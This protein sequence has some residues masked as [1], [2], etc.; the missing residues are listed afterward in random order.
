MTTIHPTQPNP[1]HPHIAVKTT[2]PLKIYSNQS[3]ND[4]QWLPMTTNDYQWLL[5]TIKDYQRLSR[6]I[7]DYQRLSKGLNANY[8]RWLCDSVMSYVTFTFLS[9]ILERM[10]LCASF[11]LSS[12]F[13]KVIS[14]KSSHFLIKIQTIQSFVKGIFWY[15]SIYL[16][17]VTLVVEEIQFWKIPWKYAS[18]AILV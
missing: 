5:K 1:I 8:G 14:G 9:F 3:T 13:T 17:D 16:I 10:I 15:I 12:L 6:T 2:Y 4:N 11:W 7:K 18:V